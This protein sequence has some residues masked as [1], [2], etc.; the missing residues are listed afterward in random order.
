[1]DAALDLS[2]KNVLVTGGSMGI[3]Y[4]V[5]QA[6]LRAGASI[7]ICARDGAEV[8]AAVE[9]LER[10]TNSQ[11]VAGLAADVS[12][13]AQLDAALDLLESRFGAVTSL[14]HAAAVQGPMGEITAV[15]PTDWLATVRVDLFG[16]FLA[17]RQTAL[18]L[19]KTGGRIVLFSGGGAAAPR[20]DLTAYAC[21]KAGVVRLAE[22]AAIELA[23]Y[24]IEV[25]ALSPG[26]VATRML[27][28]MR[29]AGRAPDA[30]PV[31]ASVGAQAAAFLISD[32][33][34]GITGKLVAAPYDDWRRL[35]ERLREIEETDVFTL[36]RIV[37]R[38]RGMDWQ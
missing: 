30:E 33:A 7:V 19:K 21:S 34:R 31:D 3:G 15:D 8:R 38:D 29:A 20:P 12:D 13:R 36:R 32:R 18:R 25:N 26:L 6:C 16:A 4:A 9:R 2:A 10:E 35:P 17:L 37:P 5:G 22:T 11:A 1:M 23:P 27:E 28:Q 14:V 24:G